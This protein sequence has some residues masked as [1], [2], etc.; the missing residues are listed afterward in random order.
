SAS[1]ASRTATCCWAGPARP[2]SR[3]GWSRAG[4]PAEGVQSSPAI[5]PAMASSSVML[6]APACRVDRG[7][8]ASVARNRAVRVLRPGVDAAADVVDPREAEGA[9][10]LGGLGAALAAV[11]Q[12]GDGR[13]LRQFLQLGGATGL[14][15]QGAERHVHRGLF[16]LRCGAH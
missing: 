2:S 5:Q 3:R 15:V 9:E 10:V 16:T 8:R 6:P 7:T 11:A 4:S 13:V 1:A 12:E 14:A